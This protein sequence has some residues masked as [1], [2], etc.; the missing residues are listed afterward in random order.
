MRLPAW[1]ARGSRLNSPLVTAV[2][3]AGGGVAFVLARL[4]VV[5]KG[6][7][8]RFVF[9]GTDF[10]NPSQAP[11]GL[12]VFAG[13]GYDGQF[14]Y[15][16][17]LDPLDFTRTAFGITLDTVF[18]IQRIGL[19]VLSWLA[20]GGQHAYVPEAEVAVNLAALF[21][22]AWM[23]GS[24]A[25]EAGRHAAWGLLVAGYWG[26][27]FSIG[28]D[29]PEV[30]A[31]CFLVSGLVALRRRRPIVAGILF[32]ASVLTVETALDIVAAVAVVSI[33]QVLRGRRH[34]GAQDAAWVVPGLA[35]VGWQAGVWSVVHKVP[36]RADTGNNLSVPVVHMV[37][38][39]F[40]YLG[41]LPSATAALWLAEFG[42]LA[43]IVLF[44]AWSLL[45]STVPPWEKVAW[46]ISFLVAIS[47]AKE[48]WYGTAQ[49]R[50]FEDLYL[51]SAI[52][53]L[54]SKHRLWVPAILVGVL[55]AVA[56]GHYVVNL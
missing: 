26:F 6:D 56:F 9:A 55:W 29:L 48:I 15:R 27:L 7:I 12:Y 46:V 41:K 31:S 43:I 16:L 44:A 52:V 47:L 34:R 18:R 23:G 54:G 17:A 30:V 32:A 40:H 25:A 51:Y 21:V 28:R 35:F 5:A 19:P 4:A 24:I 42:V 38:A 36:M 33:V 14:Y 2:L 22:L 50:G 13:T 11:H 8:T 49:F 39:V 45:R 53:L 1:A 3:A 10:V 20:S 37:G